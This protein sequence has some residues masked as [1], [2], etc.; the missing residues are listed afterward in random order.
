DIQGF[1][2][3]IV[4][5]FNSRGDVQWESYETIVRWLLAN[6]ADGV[7]IAGDNGESWALSIDERCALL[8]AAR[9]VVNG[10][11][12]LILGASAATTRQSVKYA[13]AAVDEGADAILLMPQTYVLKATRPELIAHFRGVADAV[14]IPIVLYNSPRRSGISMSVDDI[15]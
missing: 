13:E 9:K 14:D 5:P 3:A 7:C 2:P 4:T 12:P 8:S 15:G 1:V 10:R 6:G 11:I